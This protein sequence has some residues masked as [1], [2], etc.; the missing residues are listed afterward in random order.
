MTL[1]PG[2][3]VAATPI[4][5]LGDI[6][7]RAVEILKGV[8]SIL[9]EDT[10]HT[11]KLCSA[12]GI[13][14]PLKP[15]HEHNAAAVRPGVLDA[16]SQ[17]AKI[18]LVSDAGTPLISDPGYKLVREARE[19]G[20][21][22][23]PAPGPS[24]AIA[25]L[26]A[27]GAPSDRFLFAGFPPAKTN[28]R[29]DYFATLTKTPA[30][31]IFY[32]APSRI[33]ASLADMAAVFGDRQAALARELTKLHEEICDGTLSQLA[34]RYDQAPP[35]GEIVVVVW[36]PAREAVDPAELSTFLTD[37]LAHMSVKDAAAAAADALGVS[38]KEA[39]A[40]ALSI[41]NGA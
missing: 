40:C 15:Y 25:A 22:V 10:R 19:A 38:K 18:G 14:T 23:F 36:P 33:A 17:G 24:A 39:Y 20:I 21:R 35:K 28:A 27:V 31:L 13:A 26:S 5:N 8:D 41:K 9:C 16:L 3:Y 34:D 12:Y 32:E 6:T 29:G 37:A 30:T 7:Y 4:G 2:L 11:A 1:E